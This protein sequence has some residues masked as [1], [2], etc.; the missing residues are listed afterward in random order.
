MVTKPATIRH[1]VAVRVVS[2]L[3]RK[4]KRR[5]IARSRPYFSATFMIRSREAMRGRALDLKV[6]NV[7]MILAT[8]AGSL[9]VFPSSRSAPSSMTAHRDGIRLHGGRRDPAGQLGS[10]PLCSRHAK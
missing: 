6:S 3:R 8:V 2:A 10:Y 4:G 9:V 5:F 1:T 7:R